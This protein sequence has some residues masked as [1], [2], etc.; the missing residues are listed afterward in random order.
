MGGPEAVQWRLA[1][2]LVVRLAERVDARCLA[3]KGLV[4][5]VQGLREPRQ[6]ADVDFLVAPECMDVLCE[7]ARAAGWEE[8]PV[9]TIREAV[10]GHAITLVHPSW[11]VSIDLH[12]KFPGLIADAPTAFDALWQ[13]AGVLC[14]AGWEVPCTDRLGSIL[15]GV[16]NAMRA[17]GYESRSRSEFQALVKFARERLSISERIGLV[18]LAGELGASDSARPFLTQLA[19]PLPDPT[20]FGESA[21]LDYWRAVVSSGGA[22]VVRTMASPALRGPAE[23]LRRVVAGWR[24]LTASELLADRGRPPGVRHVTSGKWKYTWNLVARVRR[25]ARAAREGVVLLPSDW[26]DPDTKS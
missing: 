26:L 25:G 7:A 17:P 24:L 12:W 3:I 2:G 14:V 1:Y 6:S 10:P 22:S 15:V 5:E 16:L 8:L 13:R 21:E 23:S 18:Q 9:P 20:A 11:A 19:V 4:A